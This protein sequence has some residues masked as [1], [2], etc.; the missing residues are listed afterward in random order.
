MS[1]R[2]IIP[3]EQSSEDEKEDEKEAEQDQD[4]DCDLIPS[5]NEITPYAYEPMDSDYSPIPSPTPP[6]AEECTCGGC[7]EPVDLYS[8]TCCN[9]EGCITNN[10]VFNKMIDK[11]RYSL[12]PLM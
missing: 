6:V 10:A 8:V 3:F 12:K 2:R 1:Y 7:G 4:T 11:E 9:T 5:I